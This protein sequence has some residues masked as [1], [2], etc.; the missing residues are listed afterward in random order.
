MKDLDIKAIPYLMKSLFR[1]L[2]RYAV[3]IFIVVIMLIYC[4][5]V[6]KI[7]LLAQHEPSDEEVNDQLKTSK[8]LKIDQDSIAKIGQLEDQ[9]VSVKSLFKEA[10]DNPFSE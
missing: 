2:S 4:F 3:L 5:L 9:N 10:R 6:L 1:K 8:R 7:N